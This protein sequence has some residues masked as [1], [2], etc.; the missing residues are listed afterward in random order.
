M[1][2]PKH[3][4]CTASCCPGTMYFRELEDYDV[5]LNWCIH[6]SWTC[7]TCGEYVVKDDGKFEW[8]ED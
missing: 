7:D 8:P 2:T 5:E 6:Y 3:K 1:T 4:P